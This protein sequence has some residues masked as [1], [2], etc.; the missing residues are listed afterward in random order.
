M[1]TI[2][3][4]IMILNEA[5]E[6]MAT[7][8]RIHAAHAARYNIQGWLQN[9]QEFGVDCVDWENVEDAIRRLRILKTT[10]KYPL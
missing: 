3:N 4:L 7:H 9:A 8:D 6:I 2:D 10:G 1:N 5:N